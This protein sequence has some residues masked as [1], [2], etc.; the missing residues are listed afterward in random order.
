VITYLRANA[1]F[2]VSRIFSGVAGP[3][4][5]SCQDP[6]T[7]T[8][9]STKPLYPVRCERNPLYETP[10]P[11]IRG[12]LTG[13]YISLLNDLRCCLPLLALVWKIGRL[14]AD[15][16]AIPRTPFEQ[17]PTHAYIVRIGFC[18]VQVP[19]AT[20]ISSEKI[21]H[22]RCFGMTRARAVDETPCISRVLQVDDVC[23]AVRLITRVTVSCSY[24]ILGSLCCSETGSQAGGSEPGPG[25]TSANRQ[26][27]VLGLQQA[28]DRKAFRPSRQFDCVIAFRSLTQRRTVVTEIVHRRKNRV[29]FSPQFASHLP[30]PA[31]AGD[32]RPSGAQSGVQDSY[33]TPNGLQILMVSCRVS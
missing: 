12:I 16:V 7:P 13:L 5:L 1:G 31:Y 9:H 24:D 18:L 14:D 17:R 20:G 3:T 30:E 33:E 22:V 19:T 8:L 2:S 25:I 23:A 21:S 28:V 15:H 6:F 10:L 32:Q 29:R 27:V 11:R 4:Q 26:G